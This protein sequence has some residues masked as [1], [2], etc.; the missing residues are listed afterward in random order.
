MISDI[1][2]VLLLTVCGGGIGAYVSSEY[3]RHTMILEEVSEM[4]LR[5]T[6]LMDFES[7]TVDE[8]VRKLSDC[9]SDT[10][11][12]LKNVS[13]REELLHALVDNDDGFAECD[14]AKLKVLFNELG[15]SDKPSE[16]RR[17]GSARAYFE[18]R[19]E[20]ERPKNEQKAKLASALGL[21]GGI[22]TAV[23]LL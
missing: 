5:M 19:A 1:L 4:L 6:L 8:I 2:G 20:T 17:I 12:F 22:L 21:M 14:L 7:P 18:R 15:S 16:L 3:K 9:R 11:C 10:P 23:L 13:C